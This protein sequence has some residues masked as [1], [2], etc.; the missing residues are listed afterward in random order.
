MDFKNYLKISDAQYEKILKNTQDFRV[1]HEVET[2]TPKVT[3]NLPGKNH[4]TTPELIGSPEIMLKNAL[5]GIQNH[6]DVGDDYIPQARIEFGTGQVAHAFGCDMYIPEKSPVCNKNH[7]LKELE[8][9]EHMEI[10]SIYAGW[11]EKVYEFTEF[12]ME[13][14]PDIVRMQIPDYQGPFNNAELVRGTDILYDFYDSPEHVHMLLDKM[15]EYQIEL[16][17]YYRKLG[18]MEEGYFADWGVYWKGGARIANCSLD[19]IS[20]DFYH[21]FIKQYD[22]KFFQAIG[23]GRIHYCGGHDNGMIDGVCSTKGNMGLDLDSEF[24]DIWEI[25][26]RIPKETVL[27]MDLREEHL[28]RILAGDVPAK[29]NVIYTVGAPNVEAGR[30]LYKRVKEQLC[31]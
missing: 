1:F 19:L 21:Q 15:T 5:D 13:H 16:T 6:I 7:V 24:H 29:K 4:F 28:K 18:N 25:C 10:P 3:V 26:E 2:S 23:G 14:K 22:E 17:N 31:M 20:A 30:E 11:M 8:E 27:L 9:I 12:Y